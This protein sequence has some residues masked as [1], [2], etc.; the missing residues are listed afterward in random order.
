MSSRLEKL[1]Q[2]LPV[3]L[4]NL[5]ISLQG[6]L[7]NRKRYG[8]NYQEYL[9]NL[10][11][12]Q[13]L[14]KSELQELQNKLL[15][16]LVLEA[17]E[18]V[19]YYRDQWRMLGIDPAQINLDTI[20]KLPLLEKSL[21]RTQ[22]QKFIN[23]PR[24]K[25]GTD[26]GH[27]SG[28]S[29]IPLIF[30][31]DIDSIQRNL[32]FR[33]R[34]YR[35][36]G[37]TGKERSARFSGR[38][39]LGKH[40]CPPY[41]RHNKPENQ[42]LF[43]S[44]HLNENTWLEYFNALKQHKIAFLDGYPSSIFSLAQYIQNAGLSGSWSPWAVILTGEAVM[45]YQ[46]DMIS[47]VFRAKV[48]D[49]YSSSEGATFV[50][51][52]AAGSHHINPESGIIEFI[53]QDGS[54]AEPGQEVEM[55]ITSFFQ[56]SLPLI[57]YRIGDSGIL[58]KDQKCPCG[59]SFPVIEKIVGREDDVLYTSE[60]GRIGSA[61]LS[62][63]LYKLPQRFKESQIE[64]IGIDA[65]VFRYVPQG[66]DLDQEERQIIAMELYKRLGNS[67]K[68]DFLRVNEIPKGARGKSQ[69]VKGWKKKI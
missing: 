22:T 23:P 30:Q 13:W 5:A 31:Y 52:C 19:P 17:A 69:L 49:F 15:S 32:A 48:Y 50:T 68:I 28:T 37:L 36:A 40:E 33:E 11:R 46:R 4:Q 25:H 47:E 55:V 39:L 1:Y 60:R 62:T 20:Q 14:S 18:N 8:G 35:W 63:A 56:K 2:R 42:W 67:I 59:C 21:L 45:D 54:Y 66:V 7:Y 24:L 61:G 34:Q 9:D 27:T 29:G 41:W 3:C 10:M 16:E 64:Q 51:Q 38:I 57:R 26:E 12:S 6:G 58:A 53:K 43:S 65:F 44:Y